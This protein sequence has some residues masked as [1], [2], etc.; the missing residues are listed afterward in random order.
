MYP[1]HCI[2]L[3]RYKLNA[4]YNGATITNIEIYADLYNMRNSTTIS[5]NTVT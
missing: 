5:T 1:Y 3:I 2:N 4:A